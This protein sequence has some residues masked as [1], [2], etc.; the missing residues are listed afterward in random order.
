KVVNDEGTANL[1]RQ[2]SEAGIRHFILLSSILA[3]TENSASKCLDDHSCPRPTSYYGLSKLAAE[4]HAAD[5]T[6]SGGIGVS[7]RSPL[8]YGV[9]AGG[10]WKQLQRL[11]ASGVPLPFGAVNNRRSLIAVENLA[12][13]IATVA[14]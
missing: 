2:T 10:R 11:A 7:L 12:D 6:R 4:K 9:D 1:V 14:G 5:F 13:A 8:I 3:V